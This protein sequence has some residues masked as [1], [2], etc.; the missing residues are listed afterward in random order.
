MKSEQKNT[1]VQG[2]VVDGDEVPPQY[3]LEGLPA[4]RSGPGSARDG[5]HSK[6]APP[7]RRN[8]SRQGT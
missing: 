8:P 1:D 6:K 4:T 5:M 7:R 2:E 3:R